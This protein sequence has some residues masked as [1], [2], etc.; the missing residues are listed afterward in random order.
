VITLWTSRTRGAAAA[1]AV[2]TPVALLYGGAMR[3]RRWAYDTGVRRRYRLPCPAVTVGGLAVGG[4][5]KT[6]L[7]SWIAQWYARRGVRPA[8]LLRNYGG[9]EAELHRVAEP[10][11]IVA[12]GADRLHA[13]RRAVAAGAQVLVLDDGFQHLRVRPDVSLVLVSAESVG[14]PRWLLPAGPWR[15]GW[16]TVRYADLVVLTVKTADPVAVAQAVDALRAQSRGRPV[17]VARLRIARLR[18]LRTAREIALGELAGRRVLAACGIADPR[19]FAAQL[20][21]AGADVGLRAWRDHHPFSR[22]NVARLL[23]GAADAD[24]VVVTA[25]DAVKLRTRWPAEAPEPLVA[26]LG[27]TWERGRAEVDRAL[28]R[29]LGDLP[30]RARRP[31]VTVHTGAAA[32]PAAPRP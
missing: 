15:E 25:K 1:R 18:G 16:G 9:D 4:A 12:T 32:A 17:A 23:S 28:A 21:A 10:R 24:D 26:E 30:R 8:V 5:G 22:R 20:R 3:A 13:G 27:I 31:A 6:P 11:A 7:A 19:A 29:C 14:G 2:L